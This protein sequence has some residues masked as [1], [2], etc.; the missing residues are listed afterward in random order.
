MGLEI[1]VD[2]VRKFLERDDGGHGRASEVVGEILD[3][4]EELP[5]IGCD[6]VKGCC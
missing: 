5:A 2:A 1:V 4:E 3:N 6:L